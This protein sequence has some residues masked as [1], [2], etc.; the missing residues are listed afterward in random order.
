MSYAPVQ[1][2]EI[3]EDAGEAETLRWRHPVSLHHADEADETISPAFHTRGEQSE[4]TSYSAEATKDIIDRDKIESGS[5]DPPAKFWQPVWLTK[6]VLIL[7]ALL[8]TLIGASLLAL[9]RVIKK[10]NGVSLTLTENHYAWTY[11]PT[12][13]LVLLIGLWRQVDY[14]TKLLQPWKNLQGKTPVSASRSLL[15]DYVLRFQGLAL[16]EAVR[17]RESPVVITVLGVIFLKLLVIFSTGL[18][19]RSQ[20]TFTKSGI[21]AR[22][23]L[24]FDA[25]P[26]IDSEGFG[27]YDPDP[28]A[29]Q[30]DQLTTYDTNTTQPV[31]LYYG[32]IS[33]GLKP[34]MGYR[35]GIAFQP[36]EFTNPSD[37]VTSM[38]VMVDAFVPTTSCETATVTVLAPNYDNSTSDPQIHAKVDTPTCHIADFSINMVFQPQVTD[39]PPRDISPYMHWANCSE[40]TQSLSS[41]QNYS[42]SNGDWR[43]FLTLTDIA[44]SKPNATSW[45]ADVDTVNIAV[46]DIGYR[47]STVP[48]TLTYSSDSTPGIVLGTPNP[49][50]ETSQLTN[51][52][53]TMLNRGVIE[54]LASTGFQRNT[55]PGIA[56]HGIDLVSAPIFGLMEIVAGTSSTPLESLLDAE[57]M[58]HAAQDVF[59]GISALYALEHFTISG[60]SNTAGKLVY[61]EQRLHVGSVALWVM[62]SC[63]IA[64]AILGILLVYQRANHVLP[65]SPDTIEAS[66]SFAQTSPA[67]SR[68]LDGTGHASDVALERHLGEIQFFATKG[69]FQI[70]TTSDE[71]NTLSAE[72]PSTSKERNQWVPLPVQYPMILLTLSL[73]VIAIVVLEVLQ[74]VSDSHQGVATTDDDHLRE[75][76]S[77]VST[78]VLVGIATL[79]GGLDYTVALF[80]PFAELRKSPCSSRRSVS[81]NLVRRGVDAL[82]VSIRNRHF[83]ATLSTTAVLIGSVLTII[84]SGLWVLN[85]HVNSQRSTTAQRLDTWDPTWAT[86]SAANDSG[87]ALTLNMI[88]HQN[89]T[90][91]RW[92]WDELAFPIIE[93]DHPHASGLPPHSPTTGSDGP[94]YLMNLSALRGN[95]ECTKVPESGINV[96]TTG[97]NNFLATIEVSLDLPPECPAGLHENLTSVTRQVLQYIG[98]SGDDINSAFM[99]EMHDLHLHTDGGVTDDVLPDRDGCPSLLFAYAAYIEANLTSP[100]NITV[101]ACSQALQEVQTTIS[102]N[103]TLDGL[104]ITNAPLTD[105]SSA[106]LLTNGTAGITAFPFRI[107]N[108]IIENLQMKND[109]APGIW[110]YYNAYSGWDPFF[111]NL[112]NAPEGPRSPAELAGP[113]N[114]DKLLG[115][116]NHLYRQYMAQAINANMRRNISHTD[117]APLPFNVRDQRSFSG[118]ARSNIMRLKMDRTSKIILQVLLSVMVC[119]G[120]GSLLLVRIRGSLPHNPG[121]IAGTMSLVVGSRWVE[122]LETKGVSEEGRRFALGWWKDRRVGERDGGEGSGEGV[123][124]FGVDVVS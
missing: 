113:E 21:P 119:C 17:F 35:D 67:I 73:P 52:T 106:Q 33:N 79:F 16:L 70:M 111:D 61:V 102:F 1:H 123:H 112:I 83:G 2:V 110:Y 53:N 65:R 91:P 68:I 120:A 93:I 42:V 26:W 108:T 117:T 47:M 38:T 64:L 30:G 95:L 8:F 55:A 97:S 115:A 103:S 72:Q 60:Q 41:R 109:T 25:Q 75:Y 4:H 51:L 3:S 22:Q 57:R 20:T 59:D 39:L 66:A 13:I 98:S 82:W 7:L 99:A 94:A 96:S 6:P 81:T 87:A 37:N 80:T 85:T 78:L 5:A 19:V 101:F 89:L 62:F 71:V 43:W 116:I 11:G 121:S 90:Y 32:I 50:P 49:S 124:R 58:T 63:A 76:V 45:T 88:L 56:F 74:Q 46:C 107:Q 27:R 40:S 114:A 92:T 118:T 18:L 77:W 9:W 36:F 12:A 23:S 86:D 104:N 34:P 28:S 14:Y 24:K 31:Y 44:Y 84:S 48:L 29:P 54:A 69:V 122:E 100:G 15:L 10:E 105:E